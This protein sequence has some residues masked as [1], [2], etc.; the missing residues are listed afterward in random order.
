MR[1]AAG[2]PVL[3]AQAVAKAKG[4]EDV[5]GGILRSSYGNY[6]LATTL[7]GILGLVAAVLVLRIR[8]RAVH[9]VTA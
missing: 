2:I 4:G 3:P 9:V 1:S 8:S 7:S 6:T 5:K